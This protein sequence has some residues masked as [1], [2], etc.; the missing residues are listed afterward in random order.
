MSGTPSALPQASPRSD[1]SAPGRV[2]QALADLMTDRQT[3]DAVESDA[4]PGTV[5]YTTAQAAF[6][7]RASATGLRPVIVSG[8]F[9]ELSEPVR[10][11]LRYHRGGWAVQDRHGEWRNGLTGRRLARPSQAVNPARATDVNELATG[12]LRPSRSDFAQLMVCATARHRSDRAPLP[13][14]LVELLMATL[15]V[16]S[17]EEGSATWAFGQFEP[18]LRPWNAAEAAQ[19]CQRDQAA[20]KSHSAFMIAGSRAVPASLTLMVQPR[21]EL[22]QEHVTGLIGLG[23][24]GDP[25]LSH[26]LAAVDHLME[27]LATAAGV[28]FALVMVRA[29]NRA[30]TQPPVLPSAPIPLSMLLGDGLVKG[31]GIDPGRALEQFQAA[32]AL[33]GRGLMVPLDAASSGRP[34]LAEVFRELDFDRASPQMGISPQQLQTL[35]YAARR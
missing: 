19:V 27:A 23:Q 17:A 30:L 13:G 15:A 12:H 31:L 26:K 16:A 9:T 34:H 24:M 11:A 1:L 33:G 22:V 14:E 18:A 25:A 35:H 7:R 8:E 20:G 29:G 32:P 10:Q 5:W 3:G 6:M 28:T 2:E 4:A 21:G